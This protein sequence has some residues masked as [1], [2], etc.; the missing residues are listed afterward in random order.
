MPAWWQRWRTAL[1]ASKSNANVFTVD[2]LESGEHDAELADVEVL[3]RVPRNDFVEAEHDLLDLLLDFIG[4]DPLRQCLDVVLLV[5][6][7]DQDVLSIRH[8]LNRFDDAQHRALSREIEAQLAH[9]LDVIAQ[10][11]N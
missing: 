6:V 7:R 9:R 1:R 11:P 5:L 3:H 2:G 8:Q 4:H 10:H